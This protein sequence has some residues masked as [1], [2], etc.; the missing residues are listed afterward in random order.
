MFTQFSCPSS[1]LLSWWFFALAKWE[2]VVPSSAEKRHCRQCTSCSSTVSSVSTLVH[3]L[4]FQSESTFEEVP[5]VQVY[6]FFWI[7]WS[8][9]W[10]FQALC[11]VSSSWCSVQ[12]A[13]NTSNL[14][15]WSASRVLCLFFDI[16]SR[17]F[18]LTFSDLDVCLRPNNFCFSLLLVHFDAWARA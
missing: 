1:F 6:V 17:T 18:F 14:E 4:I 11:R 3:V 5:I 8:S 2:N 13:L 9:K 15:K 7:M 16:T 10:S 12:S